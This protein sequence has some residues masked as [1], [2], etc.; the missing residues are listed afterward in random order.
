ML[1]TPLAD[2][3]DDINPDELSPRDALEKLYQLRVMAKKGR[4]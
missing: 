2:A 3:L 4:T 1:K